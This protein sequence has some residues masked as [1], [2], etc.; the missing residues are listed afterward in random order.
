M[1]DGTEVVCK[2]ESDGSIKLPEHVYKQLVA[3][4][5]SVNMGVQEYFES[6]IESFVSE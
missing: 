1:Y 6:I 3:D 4:A 5:K 2:V